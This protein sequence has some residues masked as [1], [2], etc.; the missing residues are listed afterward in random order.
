LFDTTETSVE[1]EPYMVYSFGRCKANSELEQFATL[2]AA[3]SGIK[4]V[5]I[6]RL[7]P[8]SSINELSKN[9]NIIKNSQFAVTDIY[10]FAINCW[11]EKVPTLT[12]GRGNSY[13][14]QGTLGDKKKEIFNSQIL[15]MNYYHYFENVI[16]LIIND[17]DGNRDK[18]L[19]SCLIQLKNK[20]ALTV[21]FD[22]IDSQ[23]E[24]SRKQLISEINR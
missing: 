15:A 19:N 12:I 2:L 22:S 16:S 6:P 7:H 14:G 11:R 3:K 23:I 21:V 10:H 9:L 24:Y 4:A 8:K 13:P 1:P 5:G 18:H 20:P 17:I